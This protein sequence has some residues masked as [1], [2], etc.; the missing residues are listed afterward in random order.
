[1][2]NGCKTNQQYRISDMQRTLELLRILSLT[3]LLTIAP[4]ANILP[5]TGEGYKVK[6]VV[7]D[8][9]HGGKDPGGIG[10]GRYQTTES[11]IVLDVGLKLRDYINEHFPE[12]EVIMTRETDVFLKL[13]ERT[14]IAN[15][16]EAD[17]FISIHCN[18][19]SSHRVYG[20]ETFV[21]GMHKT[22]SNLEVAKREN[23]VIYLEE[24]Y[25]ENY[26]GFD[27]SSPESMIALS[28]MQSE[29]LEQSI[30]MSGLLQDQFRERVGRKDRGV[31][32]AGY[33]VI[34]QTVMPSI[35]TEIGFI[36]NPGEE[37]FLNSDNG[38]SYIASA[39]YRAFK[40]YKNIMD[41]EDPELL[42]DA[43]AE[44]VKEQMEN[45]ELSDSQSVPD[46]V[47][48]DSSGSDS[49][50]KN[51]T[52]TDTSQKVKAD[53]A[54]KPDEE[55][56][57]DEEKNSPSNNKMPVFHVQVAASVSPISNFEEKFPGLDDVREIELKNS[58]K[59]ASGTYTNM[60][61]AVKRQHEI[62][63]SGYKDAFVI[64]IYKG[65]RIPLREAKKLTK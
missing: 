48:T 63:E 42:A 14:E 64:A 29:F 38:I 19:T 59:Y 60:G 54:K 61:N 41:S 52:E 53:S 6:K 44:V 26:E 11:D 5:Q 31:K 3:L 7:I 10:T 18:T 8:P 30:L 56:K 45:E 27:P 47:F 49:T 15:E 17:L 58:Y 21:L 23:K 43:Q 65:K 22:E 4:V 9:G 37:D 13:I 39:I 62:R 12:V 46:D 51:N 35:L 28:M 16:A 50:E 57:D 34:S 20:T 32:Q 33:W 36:T 25:E 55:E 2:E 24:N 1:M 40:E